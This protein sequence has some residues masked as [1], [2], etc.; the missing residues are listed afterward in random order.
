MILDESKCTQV[1]PQDPKRVRETKG[2]FNWICWICWYLVS[3][4]R[5]QATK[6]TR[7]SK[8]K[9][10]PTKESVSN[11]PPIVPSNFRTSTWKDMLAF[12]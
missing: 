12:L 8:H 2:T 7:R 6:N 5:H 10:P 11:W 9:P 1:K 4:I 3:E